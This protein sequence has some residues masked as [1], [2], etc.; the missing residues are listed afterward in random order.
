M[1]GNHL[2][3]GT[4]V[5]IVS[6]FTPE[7]LVEQYRVALLKRTTKSTP[8]QDGKPEIPYVG[9]DADEIDQDEVKRLWRDS[10]IQ[11][12]PW[13][14]GPLYTHGTGMLNSFSLLSTCL[15]RDSNALFDRLVPV[16][17]FCFSLLIRSCVSLFFS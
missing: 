17:I 1:L 3:Y 13:P 8:A 11:Q 10:F 2:P 7:E 9:P 5:K 12:L 6:K 15:S 16:I 14:L 4:V